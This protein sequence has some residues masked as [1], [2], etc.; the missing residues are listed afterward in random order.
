MTERRRKYT[1]EFK[2]EAVKLVLEHGYKITEAAKNL[3][4]H[5][6][7]LG[8]W[9]RDYE[10]DESGNDNAASSAAVRAELNRLRKENKQLK[11]EREILKKAAAFF[12]REQG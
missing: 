11:L 1:Q 9:K 8:R 3:G 10:G 12:A 6:N 7:L 2:V 5:P 4:V